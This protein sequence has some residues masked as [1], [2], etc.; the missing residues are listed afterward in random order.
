MS[1]ENIA[2]VESFYNAMKEGNVP[3]AL[4]LLDPTIVWSE[5]ENFLY[6][7][8]S[9]YMGIDDLVNGLFLRLMTEWEGFH[10]APEKI[11]GTG[12]TVAAIGRYHGTYRET[13]KTVNAQVVHVYT[14]SNGKIVRFQ[15]YTDTAQFRDAVTA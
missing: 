10:A 15:Q 11:I 2:V 1:Q 3:G 12:D 8:Q 9:P 14:I 4:A 7:D 6:A 5:A 13:G